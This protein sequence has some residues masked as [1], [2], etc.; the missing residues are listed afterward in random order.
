LKGVP[1]RILQN[2]CESVVSVSSH[3]NTKTMIVPAPA[4][5]TLVAS[6]LHCGGVERAVVSLAGGLV[7]RGHRITVLT[8]S[9]ADTDFFRLPQEIVR[10]S[11]GI[12]HGAPT[13]LLRLLPSTLAKLKALR[14]AI[15]ATE[16]E[17]V[18]SHAPQTDAASAARPEGSGDRHRAR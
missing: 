9:D 16:P 3:R 7:A 17:V 10:S 12:R 18:I 1:R 5:L 15:D 4:R 14:A 2:T 6:G 8:F 13:P 11:L